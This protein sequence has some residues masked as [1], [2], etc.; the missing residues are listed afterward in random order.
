M[1]IEQKRNTFLMI[2]QQKEKKNTQSHRNHIWFLI[3]IQWW[4]LNKQFSFWFNFVKPIKCIC[5]NDDFKT[6][7][8]NKINNVAPNW[9]L[10]KSYIFLWPKLTKIALDIVGACG[11]LSLV[12]CECVCKCVCVWDESKLESIQFATCFV[13]TFLP[14][15]N[16]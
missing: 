12:V 14:Q 7:N 6:Q 10:I 16:T 8:K 4:I 13:V 1:W 5:W 11:F 15:L 3:E 9:T 2:E